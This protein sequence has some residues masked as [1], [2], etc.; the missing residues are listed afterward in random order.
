MIMKIINMKTIENHLNLD[1]FKNER[2]SVI[3]ISQ[4]N[5]PSST[6]IPRLP[7]PILRQHWDGGQ[8]QQVGKI[9]SSEAIIFYF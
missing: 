6:N 5:H 2:Q 7:Q 4:D 3:Y 8:Q 9:Y 1:I